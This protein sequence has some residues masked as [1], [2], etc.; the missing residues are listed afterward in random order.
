MMGLG[1]ATIMNN[2]VFLDIDGPIIPT[3]LYYLDSSCSLKRSRMDHSALG[4]I[5]FV[6]KAANAKLVTNSSHNYHI[7]DELDHRDL[8][9]DLIAHGIPKELFHENWRTRFGSWGSRSR[10]MTIVEWIE[11]NACD[12]WVVFDDVEV[13]DNGKQVLIDFNKGICRDDA[14]KAL[15]ILGVVDIPSLIF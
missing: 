6:L 10:M 4:W 12:N 15:E 7:V 8:R 11:E 2:I 14:Y 13:T 9:S 3:P 5:V 1:G